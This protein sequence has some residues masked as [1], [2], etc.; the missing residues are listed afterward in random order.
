MQQCKGCRV[1][2][3]GDHLCATCEA[4]VTAEA[5]AGRKDD[6]AKVRADLYSGTAYL[7]TC[8]GLTYGVTKYAAWN[9]AK[10]LQYSRVFGALLRHLFAWYGGQ[11]RDAE[12]G[13]SHL[14][15]AGCCLMFLQHYHEKPAMYQRFDDRPITA[16]GLVRTSGLKPLQGQ[17]LEDA[18][19][20]MAKPGVVKAAPWMA[21]GLLIG[22]L[23]WSCSAWA[24]DEVVGA[25]YVRCHDGDTCTVTIAG[26]PDVFGKEI[27][28]R[29]R[30]IDA[31]E[32]RAKCPKELAKAQAAK[33]ITTSMVSKAQSLRLSD[34]HRDKYFRINAT[35]WA[36][37]VNVNQALL[38][39][40]YAVP[41]TGQGVKEDWCQ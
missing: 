35:V 1:L 41:Y 6:Q 37:G 15:H 25:K 16:D 2:V 34:V 11:E 21:L 32:L 7:A 28:V 18:L 4:R 29:F 38:D 24:Y 26:I 33:Q 12:S 20:D 22:L 36:D 31:P 30:G 39:M 9:W 3:V 13:L 8:R 5:A 40:G 19:A 23:A 10:G 27:E 17:D 14:D